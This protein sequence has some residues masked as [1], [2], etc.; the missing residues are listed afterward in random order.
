[1]AQH[2]GNRLAHDQ[3]NQVAQYSGNWVAQDGGNSTRKEEAK[4]IHNPVEIISRVVNPSSPMELRDDQLAKSA[5]L[6]VDL[7]A[8]YVIESNS[9]EVFSLV[10]RELLKPA[11]T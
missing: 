5:F 8:R 1:M 6:L 7:I 11:L 9:P 3:G 4:L 2:E 10:K